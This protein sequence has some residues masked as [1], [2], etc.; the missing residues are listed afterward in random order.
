[1]ILGS[2][3]R[4]PFLL[5]REQEFASSSLDAQ[6]GL[7]PI[8]LLNYLFGGLI[9]TDPFPDCGPGMLAADAELGCAEPPDC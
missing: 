2:R 5:S 6:S 3:E 8:S 4:T 9:I 1:M 7:E